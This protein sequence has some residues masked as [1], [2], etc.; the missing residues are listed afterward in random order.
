M[1]GF[2]LSRNDMNKRSLLFVLL[3]ISSEYASAQ[4]GAYDIALS[5]GF[6]QAPNFSTLLIN[7]SYQP[8]LTT[9]LGNAG[10]FRLAI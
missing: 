10:R 9:I 2:F 1:D 4:Q 3:F 5:A 6:Y 7:P 8:I